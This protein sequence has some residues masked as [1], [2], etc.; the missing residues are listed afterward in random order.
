[1]WPRVCVRVRVR[2]RL[3]LRVETETCWACASCWSCK[4]L[5]HCVSVVVHVLTDTA[6]R[7]AVVGSCVAWYQEKQPKNAC[8]R[9]QTGALCPRLFSLLVVGRVSLPPFRAH[10]AVFCSFCYVCLFA[11][12]FLSFILSFCQGLRRL[13]IVPA[14][15]KHTQHGAGAHTSRELWRGALPLRW[16]Y[17]PGRR[18]ARHQWAHALPA[19]PTQLVGELRAGGVGGR[20][21]QTHVGFFRH[22]LQCCRGKQ[23]D[24]WWWWFGQQR[25][26]YRWWGVAAPR[27]W[28]G[29]AA[30]A[31][32]QEFVCGETGRVCPRWGRSWVDVLEGGLGLGRALCCSALVVHGQVPASPGASFCA[33]RLHRAIYVH[34]T[35]NLNFGLGAMLSLSFVVF[36][37][38]CPF[39]VPS[40]SPLSHQATI[41]I[42][43]T[44]AGVETAPL[45]P[46]VEYRRGVFVP[47]LSFFDSTPLPPEWLQ[48]LP[49]LTLLQQARAHAPTTGFSS[50][51]RVPLPEPLVWPPSQHHQH[52]HHPRA[53]SVAGSRREA[54]PVSSTAPHHGVVHPT[55]SS[56]SKGG[57]NGAHSDGSS[58]FSDYS[59]VFDDDET[60]EASPSHGAP[61][62]PK[63]QRHPIPAFGTVWKVHAHVDSISNLREAADQNCRIVFEAF[64]DVVSMDSRPC[65]VDA[66]AYTT[67][68]PAPS[69]SGLHMSEGKEQ[70]KRGGRGNASGS[71]SGDEEEDN[72]DDDS[73][74]APSFMAGAGAVDMAPP[75]GGRFEF[76]RRSTQRLLAR[77]TDLRNYL[78]TTRPLLME[79][80]VM[81]PVLQGPSQVRML[82]PLPMLIKLARGQT[83]ALCVCVGGWG[84]G[85]DEC[86][87][88]RLRSISATVTMTRQNRWWIDTWRR[89]ISSRC[90]TRHVCQGRSKCVVSVA[91]R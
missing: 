38:P 35:N 82:P 15:P 2:V 72:D 78:A 62:S 91:R 87:R 81:T 36:T 90:R 34:R 76:D 14:V 40:L 21:Q 79:I 69:E 26:W 28:H 44:R 51:R 84:S 89:L 3:R 50:D 85:S 86:F 1:V 31:P 68:S 18:P 16:W 88:C 24:G 73:T 75:C 20:H 48:A 39:L 60:G 13:S 47:P 23:R 4:L 57:V 61:T 11:C 6:I 77:S 7:D 65:V 5:H 10:L 43:R 17:Q 8:S 71:G 83:T 9:I 32:V 64:D 22:P 37:T 52:A 29:C 66:T 80:I 54:G 12:F 63:R 42:H 56:P 19:R 55:P 25:S 33:R 49:N 30:A 27:Y 53:S 45:L 46:Q 41:G 59:D 58:D 67:T 74:G 70:G